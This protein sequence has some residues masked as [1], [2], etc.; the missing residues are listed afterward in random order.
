MRGTLYSLFGELLAECRSSRVLSKEFLDLIVDVL[1]SVAELLVEHLVGSGETEALKTPYAAV[2]THEAFERDRQARGEA[3]LLL[4]GGEHALLIVN[5]LAAEQTLGGHADDAH[6]HAV[7]AK[8]LGAGLERG[9]LRAAGQQDDVVVGVAA[10]DDVGAAS[11]LRVVVAFGQHVDVLTA[12]DKGRRG[13]GVL[14]C[15]APADGGLLGVGRTQDKHRVVAVVVLELLHEADLCLLLDGL[16]GGAVLA[17]TEGVVGPNELDGQLHQGGHAD[18]RLHVVREY[19]ERTAGG[20]D[21]AVEGHADAAACHGE[22]CHASL[23]ESTGEVAADNVV[24]LLE[25]A[26]GLVAVG[27]VGRGADHVGHLLG[28]HAQHRC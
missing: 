4:A 19:E 22:L 26:V 5:G 10:G 7:L 11:G 6:L 1:T 17:D 18:G 12:E 27:Q 13:C 9:D 2:G 16:M 24:G 3:E 21:T 25:E 14:H 8:Q 15:H 20:D 28:Q 23:E